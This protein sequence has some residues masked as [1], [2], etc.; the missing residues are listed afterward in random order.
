MDDTRR[1]LLRSGLLGAG[2]LG[3]R[4]LATGLPVSFLLDPLAAR[5]DELPCPKAGAGQYL[6]FSTS[7]TGDPI[8]TN[9]PGTYD[10]PASY[11]KAVH[12][13]DPQMAPTP[14]SLGGKSYTAAK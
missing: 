6:I 8:N 7:G 9:A 4:S 1:K 13:D 2:L 5:A 11:P 10:L 12:P 14:L 3:L